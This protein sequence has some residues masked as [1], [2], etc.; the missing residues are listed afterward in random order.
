VQDAETEDDV[1]RLAEAVDT[2]RVQ[3]AVVDPGTQQLGDRLEPGAGNEVD[4]E[5]PADPGDV[6]L[7]V[8]GRAVTRRS[9]SAKGASCAWYAAIACNVNASGSA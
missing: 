1:E 4:A 3:A 7:V 5:P 6:L 2:E 9:A 8:H